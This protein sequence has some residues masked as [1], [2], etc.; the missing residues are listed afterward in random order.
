MQVWIQGLN[1]DIQTSAG[2]HTLPT[3][4]DPPYFHWCGGPIKTND[5]SSTSS[6]EELT[7]LNDSLYY[8][9]LPVMA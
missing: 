6:T 7:G 9:S 5:V 8:W 4:S 3:L 2:F 1:I